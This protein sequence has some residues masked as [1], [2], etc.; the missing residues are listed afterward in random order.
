MEEKGKSKKNRI[1]RLHLYNKL[2]YNLYV[3]PKKMQKILA[4]NSSMEKVIT[5]ACI[6]I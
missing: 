4:E 6:E 1:Q 3:K 5:K 2:F